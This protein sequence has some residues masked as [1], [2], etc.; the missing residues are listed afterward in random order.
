MQEKIF[1]LEINGKAYQVTIN[2][3]TAHDAVVTVNGKRFQIGLKD[4]GLEQIADIRPKPVGSF[5]GAPGPLEPKAS[6]ALHRPREII[7]ATTI[8][9]PLPG[10]IQRIEVHAGEAVK[11]GQQV[12]TMEAMKMENEI[13]ATRD[14]IVK[15]I[16]VR[17]GD[18]V[19]EGDVLIELE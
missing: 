11:L 4:L 3:F 6:P 2:A 1:N 10:L 9:A 5:P 16:R 8:T 18:S 17:E 12:I 14:G 7:S 13:Q 15:R 19:N